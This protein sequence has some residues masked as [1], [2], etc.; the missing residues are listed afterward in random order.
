MQTANA[1]LGNAEAAA[2]GAQ[3]EL[4]E[5]Q[6]LVEAAKRRV[7]EL[8]KQLQYAKSDLANTKQAAYKASAA[9]HAAKVNANRNKR[10]W[11]NP[12]AGGWMNPLFFFLKFFF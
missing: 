9:A 12:S 3:Q 8:G 10:E 2:Q 4:T 6:Q 5:K 7:E 11:F 1:N